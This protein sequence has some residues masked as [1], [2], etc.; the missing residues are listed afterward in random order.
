MLRQEVNKKRTILYWRVSHLETKKALHGSSKGKMK[1]LRADMLC[2]LRLIGFTDKY[3]CLII[4]DGIGWKRDDC[5]V[6]ES[7]QGSRTQFKN[8]PLLLSLLIGEGTI[9]HCDLI[10]SHLKC[11][12]WHP[13]HTIND[14]CHLLQF[15][16][17]PNSK[18]TVSFL[19]F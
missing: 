13:F 16:S 1:L 9:D 14:S 17:I 3:I 5:Q 2:L 6:R 8:V 12:H 4:N 11:F 18:N 15:D 19:L 10:K 7:S